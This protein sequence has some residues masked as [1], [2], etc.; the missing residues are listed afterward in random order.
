MA[1]DQCGEAR[2]FCDPGISAPVSASDGV[3]YAGHLDGMLR[4]YDEV[5]GEV[6]WQYDTTA[7]HTGTNGLVGRGGG[8][9]G[10]GPTVAAGHLIVNSGYGLYFHEPG[11]LLLVF[12]A[13]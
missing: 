4:A 11:N 8:M 9:S 7:E 13:E 3:V 6:L 5:T 10:A 2:E 1:E 12:A